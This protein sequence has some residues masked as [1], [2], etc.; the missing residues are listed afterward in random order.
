MKSKILISFIVYGSVVGL[1]STWWW[2]ISDN[3][4]L[5][6]IPGVL[7]GDEAYTISIK[8]MG[9]PSSPQAH[10]SIPWVLRVPQVYVP[11]SI[12]FW[13]LIG[14]FIQITYPYTRERSD[15]NHKG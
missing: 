13:G 8:L 15:F 2:N 12:I 9:N 5:P 7:L 4:F 14:L 11:V 10:Y 3:V 6:N 1:L